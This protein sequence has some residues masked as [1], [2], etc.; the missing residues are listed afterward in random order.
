MIINRKKFFKLNFFYIIFYIIF[1]FIF[2]SLK[3]Y[4]DG[5]ILSINKSAKILNLANKSTN[6]ALYSFNNV[7]EYFYSR[8]YLLSEMD[9]LKLELE[10]A[11]NRHILDLNQENNNKQIIV[12]KK[13]FT[14]FT[15]IYDNLLIN[16]GSDDGVLEGDIVF[17]YENNLI[18]KVY[19]VNKNSSLVIL[20]SKDKEKV[21]GIIKAVKNNNTVSLK[22]ALDF[23]KNEIEINSSS[24]KAITDLEKNKNS[25]E[26]ILIDVIGYGGGDFISFIPG[27]LE[28]S[29]GDRIYYALDDKK[30]IGEVVSIEK[31]DASFYKVLL[32]RGYYNSRLNNDYYILRN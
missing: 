9:K 21:E 15:N 14:D 3:K 17:T 26:D 30:Y 6:L 23:D 19:K 22:E 2:P 1:L 28:V 31:Q 20:F 12:A 5:D 29:V 27:N 11:K 10:Q 4:L 16:K 24:S 7:I 8:K 32:I 18:G 25:I 13:I